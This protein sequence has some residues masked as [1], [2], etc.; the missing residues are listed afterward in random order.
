VVKRFGKL[1]VAS[2][3][4]MGI[5][6][7]TFLLTPLLYGLWGIDTDLPGVLILDIGL[8]I[9][10]IGLIRKKKL[11]RVK[12]VALIVLASVLSIPILILIVGLIYYLI[13]GK[14]LG[15]ILAATITIVPQNFS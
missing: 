6:V 15:F 11:G 14:P 9:Y 7:I 13:M 1:I 12:L 5:G 2:F 3:F 4:L 8:V 10:I